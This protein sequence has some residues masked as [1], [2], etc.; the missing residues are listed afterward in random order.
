[1]APPPPPT[2]AGPAAAW[3]PAPDDPLA[4]LFPDGEVGKL[5]QIPR[6][7]LLHLLGDPGDTE[8]GGVGDLPLIGEGAEEH[9]VEPA[10]REDL[11]VPDL[12]A[13]GEDQVV[14]QLCRPQLL[15]ALIAVPADAQ[16]LPGKALKPLVA[17]L[18]RGIVQCGVG[19]VGSTA[20]AGGTAEEAVIL[21]DV[22]VDD[23]ALAAQGFHRP[24]RGIGLKQRPV[25]VDMVKGHKSCF[26]EKAPFPIAR[27]KSHPGPWA[28]ADH[29]PP[30]S[31]TRSPRH[32]PSPSGG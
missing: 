20:Q 7:L 30:P 21:V 1:M 18:E 11:G 12:V 24:L 2:A 14:G 9:R 25:M 16:P 29:P 5:A 27:S 28:P 26:Q 13:A 3:G 10:V 19:V 8:G 15:Q 4:L 32:T 6:Q 17:G 23:L 22:V 31:R